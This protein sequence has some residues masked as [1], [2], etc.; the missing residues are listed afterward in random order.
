MIRAEV[1]GSLRRRAETIGD[2]DILFS[3]KEPPAVLDAFVKLPRSPPSWP[4]ARPRRASAW[5][6]ASS[7]TCGE[8]RMTSSRSPSI[9]SRVPRPTISP[10]ARRALARGC[11]SNEYALTGPDGSIACRTEAELFA[12]LGLAEIPP[13]LRE[14]AGEIEAAEIGPLPDAGRARRP[15]RY[16]PLPHRL[17][18]RRRHARR[19][20]RGG[21]RPRAEIPGNR[22]PFAIGGLRRRADIERVHAQWAEIDAL[23]ETFGDEFRL[24]KGTECDILADGSLDYPD[25]LLDGFDYVVASVHSSFGCRARR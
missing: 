9:T 7:A 20:G 5:P 12:A 14:D 2:L 3:S 4:T 15:D 21:A 19:D 18:R 25:E 16:V 22:R 24:F 10:C 23:N 6:M 11:R 8:S 1:C 17:E 13:E